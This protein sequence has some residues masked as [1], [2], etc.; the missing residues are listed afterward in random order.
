[1]TLREKFSNFTTIFYTP[2]LIYFFLLFGI[3]L[4]AIASAQPLIPANIADTN[5]LLRQVIFYG[6]GMVAT[7]TALFMGAK[8]IRLIRWPVYG[9]CFFLIIM[10]L[11]FNHPNSNLF[12]I[13]NGAA[14]WIN[15]G[16]MSLQPSEFM[17]IA[18]ILVV[19]D[20]IQKHNE[21]IPHETRTFKTD[22]N[23]II[24]AF[25][26]VL[27]PS[28]LI[29]IQP[30]SGITILILIT[31]SFML[32]AA[33]I[34][35]TYILVVAG[36]ALFFVYIFLFFVIN[37]PDF[38]INTIG[39]ESYRIDRFDALLDPFGTISGV[40][41]QLARALTGMG[42]GGVLGHGFQ[43][44]TIWFPEAHTD[45]IFAV[46][47]TD[48]G[49]IGSMTVIGIC[50]FFNLEIL[51]TAI[52]NRDHYNSHVCVGIFASLMAQ[53]FWNI[54]MLLGI[55]PITGVTLPF[56]SFGGSSVLA[57][58]IMFGLVL[59][60]HIEGKRLKHHDASYKEGILYLS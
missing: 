21:K 43:S 32:L 3:S 19:A 44:G 59:S 26:V 1:M 57:S 17:R 2:M 12:P 25:G 30:D 58:M 39:I 52:L 13:V 53:Q 55:L 10:I 50:L 29:F 11:L 36:S 45:L 38:L 22:F 15:L 24:K 56:I 60:A 41:F 9:L 5:F 33:G 51:N 16:F 6:V 34:K 40:G 7:V 18:L 54:G 37:H 23:L 49:M 31:T 35:W 46:I 20:I 8:N 27:I 48:F 42:S 4:T 47:G 28:L 14:R